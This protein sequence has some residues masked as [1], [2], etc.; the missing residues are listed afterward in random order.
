MKRL[1][2]TTLFVALG[3]RATT[4][5][6]QSHATEETPE[7]HLRAIFLRGDEAV[8]RRDGSEFATK[9]GASLET[10]AWFLS[11]PPWGTEVFSMLK[12]LDG[13]KS[14]APNSPWTL[15]AQTIYMTDVQ[16]SV[17][18]CDKALK[19]ND[20]TGILVLCTAQLVKHAHTPADRESLKAF[21]ERHDP[22]FE[23]TA[24]GLASKASA[25]L[26]VYDARYRD[27]TALLYDRAL[28]LDPTNPAALFG[29]LGDFGGR[30]EYKK[31]AE[32]I[33]PILAS[34]SSEAVHQ[35]YWYVVAKVDGLNKTD[36]ALRIQSDASDFIK[37]Q[38]PSADLVMN[39]SGQFLKKRDTPKALDAFMSLVIQLYPKSEVA[40]VVTA[41]RIQD[42]LDAAAKSGNDQLQRRKLKEAISF[43]QSPDRRSLD[44]DIIA[45]GA[46]NQ[47]ASADLGEAPR[48]AGHDTNVVSGLD[49]ADLLTALRATKNDFAVLFALKLADRKAYLPEVEQLVT[50]RIEDMIRE[51]KDTDCSGWRYATTLNQEAFMFWMSLSQWYDALGWTYLQQGKLS[52][53]ELRLVSAEKFGDF[54]RDGDTQSFIDG[55]APET[56]AHLGEMYSTK[57]EYEKAGKYFER[58][59]GAVFFSTSE[60][61]AVAGM[62]RL[63]VRQH[64]NSDGL[65][66]YMAAIYAKDSTR[67]KGLIL[68]ERIAT[69]K[70][71]APFKL[72]TLDGHKIDS[73]QLRGKYVIIN[74][75]GTWCAPCRSELP[76]LQKLYEKYKDNPDVVILTI[77]VGDTPTQVKDFMQSHKYNFTVL[78]E[79]DYMSKSGVEGFPT[80]WFLD[81]AGRKEFE[82]NGFSSRLLEEFSWRVEGMMGSPKS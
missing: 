67:R 62:K 52:D 37:R 58:S 53:A 57:G 43:L 47:F 6:A 15:T 17:A 76:E 20:D 16:E 25:L 34:V 36:Q 68:N 71:I 60:H 18:F 39:M 26:C 13:M 49:S 59:L 55:F 80:T 50:V 66:Q 28:K 32:F 2:I 65:D 31:A 45:S 81:S 30:K 38:E 1:L 10:R 14:E 70:T 3:F 12:L 19:G 40:E 73:E 23:A 78:L 11:A 29:K 54:K 48:D 35:R 72:V 56:L 63:Y 7:Q 8:M 41:I 61:P 22:L 82:K 24:D 5:F 77:D 4:L 64:G 79:G 69:P 74:F 21:V 27:D 9:A 46:L 33:S 51:L 75:W 42:D 44:A